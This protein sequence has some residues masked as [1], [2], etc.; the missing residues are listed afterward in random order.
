MLKL[1]A[2]KRPLCCAGVTSVE[3]WQLERLQIAE[4]IHDTRAVETEPG[5]LPV[6]DLSACYTLQVE[7]HTRC[8]PE[9]RVWG[10]TRDFC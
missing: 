2:P 7:N 1:P 8:V 10:V 5:L 9:G 3:A 4:A 6:R